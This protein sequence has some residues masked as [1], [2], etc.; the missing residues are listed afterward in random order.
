MYKMK[1]AIGHFQRVTVQKEG[2]QTLVREVTFIERNNELNLTLVPEGTPVPGFN[3][4]VAIS[5]IIICSLL[6]VVR[7]NL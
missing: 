2:Y 7:R 4:E 3:F 6:V 5:A 1:K